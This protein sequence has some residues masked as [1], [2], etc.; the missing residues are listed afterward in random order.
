[1]CKIEKKKKK[2]VQNR[3][4]FTPVDAIALNLLIWTIQLDIRIG[5]VIHQKK[6]LFIKKKKK[7]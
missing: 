4:N 6:K 1:M 2:L 7:G 5:G 3:R